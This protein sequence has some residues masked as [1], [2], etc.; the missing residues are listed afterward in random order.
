MDNERTRQNKITQSQEKTEIN[1]AIMQTDIGY[2]KKTIEE[3]NK[4][5]DLSTTMYVTR[6]EFWPVKT[7]V[8]GGAGMILIGV[9]GTIIYLV[10]GQ[11]I[12]TH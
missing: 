4:K 8:Y 5:F 11:H 3:V 1:V 12:T 10:T 2:I 7:I 6:A 9:M